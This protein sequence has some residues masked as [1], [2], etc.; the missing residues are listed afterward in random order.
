[1]RCLV[2][3]SCEG[4]QGRRVYW[5]IAGRSGQLRRECRKTGPGAPANQRGTLSP[6]PSGVGPPFEPLLRELV[7]LLSSGPLLPEME[8]CQPQRHSRR[9]RLRP[10]GISSW[11]KRPE[12]SPPCSL[13]GCGLVT[14]DRP[15]SQACGG[16]KSS[17][18]AAPGMRGRLCLR[19][20]LSMPVPFLPGERDSLDAGPGDPRSPVHAE[21]A[22]TL[23]RG[24]GKTI[25]TSVGGWPPGVPGIL[26]GGLGAASAAESWVFR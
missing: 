10:P 3:E 7:A 22:R 6:R 14:A 20:L 17:S 9:L 1:M 11:E 26:E 5:V 12:V 15:S 13:S 18:L 24:F 23:L 8:S 21:A 2:A 4:K 25:P 19:G 16:V